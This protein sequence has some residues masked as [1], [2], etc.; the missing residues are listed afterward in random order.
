MEIS[1][2]PSSFIG[3]V[4][5]SINKKKVIFFA[6]VSDVVVCVYI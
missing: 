4:L 1:S 5:E 3:G 2:T 6:S